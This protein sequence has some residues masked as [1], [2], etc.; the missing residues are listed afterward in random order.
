M[1]QIDRQR[2]AGLLTREQDTYRAEHPR[3]LELHRSADHLFGRVPMT[4][5]SMWAGGFPIAHESADPD[6]PLRD[7]VT[8]Q[9]M[10]EKSG[11]NAEPRRAAER[12]PR[13]ASRRGYAG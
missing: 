2:L 1:T 10:Q 6:P 13:S 9:A 4:W 12:D 5:M 8:V 7:S 3:S 11:E